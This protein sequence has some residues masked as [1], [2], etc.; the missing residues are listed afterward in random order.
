MGKGEEDEKGEQAANF[1]NCACRSPPNFFSFAWNTP[2]S[3]A[4]KCPTKKKIIHPTIGPC[5][6]WLIALYQTSEAKPQEGI[7][8]G[9]EGGKASQR[10]CSGIHAPKSPVADWPGQ[11]WGGLRGALT[12]RIG[13]Q[14]PN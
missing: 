6:F 10:R 3:L 8:E 7:A 9:G 13:P 12:A 1:L 2:L 11:P 5:A 14:H 4:A